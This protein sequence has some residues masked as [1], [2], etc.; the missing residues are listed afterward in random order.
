MPA[1]AG[2]LPP[3]L[4]A[5]AAVAVVAFDDDG[6]IL[7]ANTGMA[8]LVQHPAA[9]L[10]GQRLGAHLTLAGRVVFDNHLLPLLKLSGRAQELALQLRTADG[11]G[12]FVMCSAV[13]LA[14]G[15]GVRNECAFMPM[16]ERKRIEQELLRIKHS[17]DHMPGALLQLLRH[18]DGS[19]RLSAPSGAVRGLL[20]LSAPGAG[21]GADGDA[22]L[23]D[24]VHE[25][26]RARVS[27]EL[28]ASARDMRPWHGE[29]RL[30]RPGA[31]AWRAVEA[32]PQRLDDGRLLWHGYASDISSRKA[33]EAAVAETVR[34]KEMLLHEVNHRV[35]NSL[36]LVSSL[37]SLQAR[38]MADA[39]AGAA[40]EGAGAGVWVVGRV[41]EQGYG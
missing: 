29:F 13:R 41:A 36:Q 24:V 25:D 23:L 30:Q 19:V 16:N 35:K 15:R 6:L 5:T 28:Q 31:P 9:A 32:R 12:I 7:E 10:V 40:V 38:S 20:A 21:V 26:D 4:C 22:A 11:R 14:T 34:V 18:G 2:T 39:D 17:V 37:L 1:D 33:M 8:Q 27:E 3:G